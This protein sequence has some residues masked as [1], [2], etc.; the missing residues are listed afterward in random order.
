MP[1]LNRNG[2]PRL[3]YVVDDYTDP[4]KNAPYLVLQHGNGRSHRFWYNWVPYLSRHYRVIRPD[5]RGLG[6][7]SADFDLTK[8]FTLEHCVDDL[9]AIIDSLGADSVHVCGESMGGMIGI[10]LAALHPDRVRTLTLVSTPV[11]INEK[12]KVDFSADAATGRSVDEWLEATN[13]GMRFPSHADPGLVAWYN[14]EF[15]RGRREVQAAM[16]EVVNRADTTSYLSRVRVPV[17]GLYPQAGPLTT[18]EQEATMRRHMPQMRI[19][20]LPADY[21]KIQLMFPATCASHLLHFIAQHDG[22]AC[23]ES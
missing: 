17:L 4:W 1:D 19:V 12:G 5:V 11:Y 21:H 8:A 20:H 6:D 3:H 23:R 7:S 16:G 22:V 10:G 18:P 2:H 9:L 14:A 15:K 13:R